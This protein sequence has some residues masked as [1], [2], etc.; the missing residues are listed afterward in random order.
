MKVD[1]TGTPFRVAGYARE[2]A[3]EREPYRRQ[4][5]GG[6][7]MRMCGV[8][9]T[10][11]IEGQYDYRRRKNPLASVGIPQGPERDVVV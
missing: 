11:K 7:L 8:Y 6:C 4:T 3:P 10:D 9:R 1:A 5:A 2:A